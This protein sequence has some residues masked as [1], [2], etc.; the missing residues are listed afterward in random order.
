MADIAIARFPAIAPSDWL[1]LSEPVGRFVFRGPAPAQDVA[2][3]VIGIPLPKIPCRASTGND[4]VALWLGPDEHLLFCPREMTAALQ[5]ALETALYEQPHSL[6]DITDRQLSLL[7][8]GP[9][10]AWILNGGCPL[11]LD[12][13]A[14]PVGMCTRTVFAKTEIVLWRS[15]TKEFHIDVARSFTRYLVDVLQLIA[16]ELPP[17][18][19]D[20]IA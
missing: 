17:V 7:V 9:L 19:T 3:A 4:R 5:A 20:R 15:E 11:D 10:A 14:F 1:T 16:R 8:R 12:V 2:A 6:V 18:S 13:A